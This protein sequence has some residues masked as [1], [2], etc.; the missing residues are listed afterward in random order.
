[1]QEG[2]LKANIYTANRLF[3]IPGAEFTVYRNGEVI[4]FRISNKSGAVDTVAI[5]SPD[6][7]LSEV[8]GNVA[9]YSV[10]DITVKAPGFEPLI[11]K[12]VQVFSGETSVLNVDMIPSAD[13]PDL[14]KPGEI[15][16]KPQN[17]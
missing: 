3:P 7:D 4:A 17:L 2:Y 10:V 16:I 13:N 8:P 9:P 15:N 1:M 6:K 14:N 5:A 11:Y 12:G